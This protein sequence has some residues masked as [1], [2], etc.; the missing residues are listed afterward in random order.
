M[1]R[2]DYRGFRISA[3]PDYRGSTKQSDFVQAINKSLKYVPEAQPENISK[4]LYTELTASKKASNFRLFKAWDEMRLTI[5]VTTAIALSR[6]VK[7]LLAHK[8]FVGE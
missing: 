5:F 4:P 1:D 2:P 7:P 6:D 3:C 8:A